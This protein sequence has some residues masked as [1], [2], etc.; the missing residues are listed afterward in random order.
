MKQIFD[1]PPQNFLEMNKDDKLTPEFARILWS[2]TS[3]KKLE[4]V[5]TL[6]SGDFLTDTKE[7]KME[8]NV[9]F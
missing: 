2:R 9:G 3:I 6:I 1:F 4:I 8:S 7:I 5:K